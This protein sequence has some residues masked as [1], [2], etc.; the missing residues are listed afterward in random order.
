VK[1]VVYNLL[2]DQVAQLVNSTKTKGTHTVTFN[3]QNLSSGVYFYQL[4][5]GT[6]SLVKK[7]MFIK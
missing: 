3:A 4:E 7:M 1:L 6:T 5:A 2:G